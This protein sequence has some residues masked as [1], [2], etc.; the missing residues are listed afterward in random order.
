MASGA[1]RRPSRVP[2]WVVYYLLVLERESAL[3]F[4]FHRP[5]LT[6]IW[7]DASLLDMHCPW[8]SRDVEHAVLGAIAEIRLIALEDV[9]ELLFH[10]EHD[11]ANDMGTVE[12]IRARMR[13]LRCCGRCHY[14]KCRCPIEGLVAPSGSGPHPEGP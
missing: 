2:S 12:R 4:W 14:V 13:R 9:D 10:E 3:T 5:L 11:E 1:S 7:R 6:Q 8:C